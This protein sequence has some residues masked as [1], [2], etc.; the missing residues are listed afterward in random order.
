M[1]IKN[2]PSVRELAKD[3]SERKICHIF[4]AFRIAYKGLIVSLCD[5]MYVCRLNDQF[6]NLTCVS[7]LCISTHNYTDLSNVIQTLRH[8]ENVAYLKRVSDFKCVFLK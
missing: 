2:G 8:V 7:C 4:I 1:F 5:V 3:V 6:S